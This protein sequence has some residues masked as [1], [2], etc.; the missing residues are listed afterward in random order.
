M[1]SAFV[2]Q[3]TKYA[4]LGCATGLI[5]SQ[6]DATNPIDEK[7]VKSIAKKWSKIPGD[8]LR[9]KVY[10]T[11]DTIEYATRILANSVG[12]EFGWRRTLWNN[13]L[14]VPDS[15]DRANK[16]L[17]TVFQVMQPIDKRIIIR[18]DKS[19]ESTDVGGVIKAN[20][21]KYG[22]DFELN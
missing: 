8:E 21:R 14:F 1:L 10:E 9:F 6:L 17:E 22:Y 7:Q 12:Y 3:I 4:V 20:C 19:L 13:A 11:T 18:V 2:S 16:D 15:R 5:V